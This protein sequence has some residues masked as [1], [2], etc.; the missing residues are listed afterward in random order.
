MTW[1]EL[2]C[3]HGLSIALALPLIPPVH[4]QGGYTYNSISFVHWTFWRGSKGNGICGE[5]ALT[6]QP[7]SENGVQYSM[8]DT[9]PINVLAIAVQSRSPG[10]GLEM[11]PRFVHR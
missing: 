3:L 6:I 4:L 1:D 11:E 7:C 10:P 8:Y 9:Y 5:Y 2:Y